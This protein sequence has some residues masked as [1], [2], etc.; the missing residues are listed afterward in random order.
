MAQ[1]SKLH[2]YFR[3]PDI[4]SRTSDSAYCP[5]VQLALIG[6]KLYRELDIKLYL[7]IDKFRAFIIWCKLQSIV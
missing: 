1:G 7:L 6:S 5:Y 3:D 2:C 4:P